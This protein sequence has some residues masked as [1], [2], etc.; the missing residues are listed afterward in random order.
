MKQFHDLINTIIKEGVYKEQARENMPRTKAI[1]G[2]QMRFNLNDGFPIVTTKK[3]SFK[4]VVVELLSF[5]RGDETIEFL[6]KHNC[7][8]WNQD[9]EKFDFIDKIHWGKQYP[10]LW[11]NWGGKIL[12]NKRDKTPFILQNKINPILDINYGLYITKS[13]GEFKIIDTF[14][15][16]NSYYKIQFIKTG[17]ITS[18][19]KDKINNDIYD[20]YYPSFCGIGCL[21]VVKNDEITDKLKII[22]KGIIQRC[23]DEKKDNYKYY[24]GKGVKVSNRWKCFEYFQEDVKYILNWESKLKDWDNYDLDKDVKGGLEYSIQN[25]IWLHKTDNKRQKCLGKLYTIKNEKL[26]IIETFEISQD[27]IKKYNLHQG[28]FNSML[29][30]KRKISQGWVLIKKEELNKGIDQISNLIKGLQSNPE[31]RRHIITAWNPATLD[32]MAL[33]ACHSFV[34]FNCR[35]LS[36]E[37]KINYVMN[38][39]DLPLENLII[40]E[41]ALDHNKTPS[42][43]LDCQLYQRSGDA[44]LGIPYNISSY[45]LLTHIIAKLCNMQVGNFI[46]TLGDVHLYENHMSAVE[47]LLIRDYNL[48]K[49]PNLIFSDSFNTK[50][51]CYK[52]N[53][54]DLDDFF[55]NLDI[56]DFSLDNYQSYSAIKAEL[57]T[58]LL[59]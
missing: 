54:I 10:Y 35:P 47:E 8:I 21:G 56:Y 27:I 36:L 15:N 18:V 59:K 9:V 41:V 30:G 23:Y 25:C 17:Y 32:D 37:E 11:R 55:N 52:N 1:F 5:L 38:N 29:R 24:G 28:N 14:K 39:Y 49:L 42:Y 31:G 58:G 6:Q 2:H 53:E 26:N 13:Y 20:P 45:A 44:F 43:Y 40:T 48:Y 57:S 33:N 16:Y 22:W 50:L 19:R 51:S 46:H 12:K 34:Q 3:V 4:N 7:N